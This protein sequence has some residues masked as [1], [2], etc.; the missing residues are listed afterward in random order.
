[1]LGKK[2]GANRKRTSRRGASSK[3]EKKPVAIDWTVPVRALYGLLAI[4]VCVA[5][6]QAYSWVLAQ[7]VT[8]VVVNGDFIY[9]D[10]QSVVRQVEPMLDVGFV[11]LELEVIKQ[12]LQQEP[13]IYDVT[14]Q[15]RWPDEL[16]IAVQEQ[17]VIARWGK[18]GFINH[19]GELFTPTTA[20]A[21]NEPL[22]V[23]DGPADSSGRV[24]VHFRELNEMLQ[25]SNIS[26]AKLTLNDR[27]GWVA[28][29]DNGIEMVIG[30]GEVMEK[31]RRFLIAYQRDLISPFAAV[32][33][34]DMR[35]SNGF[36]VSWDQT[37]V[38]EKS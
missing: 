34:I 26:L 21:I 35:Y 18:N 23:L 30:D 16:I 8:R 31:V 20:V 17:R 37:I 24:M 19:R 14:I 2:S 5:V 11:K 3:Q 12:Q 13:W 32:K 4:A 36:A 28:Y 7:P 27:G 1:M 10:K 29:L 22:P 9:A 25:K 38:D 33:S 15:R 6:F